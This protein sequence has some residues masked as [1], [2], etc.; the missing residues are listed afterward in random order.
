MCLPLHVSLHRSLS[1]QVRK[2]TEQFSKA[3]LPQPTLEAA[4][5]AGAENAADD[6]VMEEDKEVWQ[7]QLP[8]YW[9]RPYHHQPHGA[10]TA[11]CAGPLLV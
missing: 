3:P 8:E 4:P 11:P 9:D 6:A 7:T 2:C 1:S 5:C 10:S